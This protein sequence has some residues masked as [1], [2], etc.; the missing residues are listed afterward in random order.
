MTVTT[1]VLPASRPRP[2]RSVANRASSSSPV[3]A[4]PVWSTATSRSASPSRA[5]PTSAPLA[6]T[7]AASDSGWVEPQPSLMLV[8]SGSYGDGVARRRPGA[9]RTS[10]ATAEAAP[11]AQSTTTRMPVEVAPLEHLRPGGRCSRRRASGS[12]DSRPDAVA[13]GGRGRGP[14]AARTR[15]SSS[16]TAASVASGSLSPPAAK[17]LTP[18]SAKGLCEAEMTAAG[19]AALRPSARPPPGVGR[20]PRSTTSAPSLASPADRAAWSSGPERRVSR[21]TRKDAGREGPGRGPPQGQDQ[22]G[23]EL[24]VG[25]SADAVG[26][27]PDP[28]AGYRFEYWGALRAFLRPYFLLS[29]SRASRVRRPAFLRVARSSGSSSSERAG[30]ARGAWRRPG[31]RRRRRRWWRRRRSPRSGW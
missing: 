29:F 22:L 27:E 16:S 7:S 5:R 18:L 8:P 10:G 26:A 9:R 23:A 14:S 12:A 17:S 1:T 30:D 20:T 28:T 2:A 6:T 15:S 19:T 4:A 11:L 13:G 3:V 21:P 25:D 24:G 31:P